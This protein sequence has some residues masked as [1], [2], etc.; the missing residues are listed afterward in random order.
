[1]E[2]KTAKRNQVLLKKGESKVG[3]IA[4][5]SGLVDELNPVSASIHTKKRNQRRVAE[6][7]T[8]LSFRN[9]DPNQRLNLWQGSVRSYT[10][11]ESTWYPMRN[12]GRL[13]EEINATGVTRDKGTERWS[14]Y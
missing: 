6:L 13:H 3:S 10:L 7:E 8:R 14:T 9:D 5:F 11:L 4:G 2:T 12:C 1:M